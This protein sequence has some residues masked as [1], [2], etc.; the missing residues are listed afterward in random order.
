MAIAG[1]MPEEVL[2]ESGWIVRRPSGEYILMLDQRPEDWGRGAI[3]EVADQLLRILV[4]GHVR[5]DLRR[6]DPR[7]TTALKAQ[8]HLKVILGSDELAPKLN[9]CRIVAP[10]A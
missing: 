7:V 6:I 8:H 5:V 3:A 1:G 10:G 2:T 4:G 9:T